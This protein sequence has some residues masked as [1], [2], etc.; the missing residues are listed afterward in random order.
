MCVHVLPATVQNGLLT[1][2]CTIAH[3]VAYLASVRSFYHNISLVALITIIVANW[4]TY[5]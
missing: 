2:S 1:A 4:N 3:I 5:E